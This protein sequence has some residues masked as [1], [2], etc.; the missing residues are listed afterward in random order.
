MLVAEFP[1]ILLKSSTDAALEAST[2]TSVFN[3]SIAYKNTSS[4]QIQLLKVSCGYLEKRGKIIKRGIS[5]LSLNSV[6]NSS[7]L[8]VLHLHVHSRTQNTHTKKLSVRTRI[9][10]SRIFWL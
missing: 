10:T 2:A 9:N 5:G 1:E 7:A 4:R 8:G 3:Y 6:Q